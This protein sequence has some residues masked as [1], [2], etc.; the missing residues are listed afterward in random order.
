MSATGTGHPR[1]PNE[2]ARFAPRR[3][4]AEP[5]TETPLEKL[6]PGAHSDDAVMIVT[7]TFC[8]C[9]PGH[10]MTTCLSEPSVSSRKDPSVSIVYSSIFRVRDL[11]MG[12]INGQNVDRNWVFAL[13]VPNLT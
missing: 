3:H 10:R 12:R 5:G 11:V 6:L 2:S 1:S 4:G 8:S 9:W 7:R 13:D